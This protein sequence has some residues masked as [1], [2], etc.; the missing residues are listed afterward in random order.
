MKALD[1]LNLEQVVSQKLNFL[2]RSLKLMKTTLD[3]TLN[4]AKFF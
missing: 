4:L 3:F 2:D 1:K